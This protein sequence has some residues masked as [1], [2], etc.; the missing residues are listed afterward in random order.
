MTFIALSLQSDLATASKQFGQT[1]DELRS[2]LESTQTMAETLKREFK[3]LVSVH[4]TNRLPSYRLFVADAGTSGS[5]GI[6]TFYGLATDSPHLPAYGFRNI[7]TSPFYRYYADAV[8]FLTK[9]QSIQVFI[10]HGQNEARWREHE[11][12][13]RGQ[14][15]EPVVLGESPDRGASTIIEKFEHYARDCAY[16]IA[17][18]TKDDVVENSGI[19]YFQA[20]PNALFE[21]GWFF[22]YLGRK[23]VL[24]LLEEGVDVLSDLSGILQKR[25]IRRVSEVEKELIRELTE[26]G[27]IVR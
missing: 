25:F 20:R 9:P 1:V 22:A 21:V 14:G 19:R 17:I 7:K 10:V 3:D 11:K 24:I 16:T 8:K 18:F 6:V 4:F 27:L 5:R 12:I 15:L 23:R 2:E 13:I 26:A